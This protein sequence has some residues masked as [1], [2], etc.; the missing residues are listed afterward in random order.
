MMRTSF[1]NRLSPVI[2]I[3]NGSRDI[4]GMKTV[5]SLGGGHLGIQNFLEAH[6]EC[7]EK[8][9]LTSNAY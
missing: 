5:V 7:F 8:R 9:N 3:A 4:I 1:S 6:C 2:E